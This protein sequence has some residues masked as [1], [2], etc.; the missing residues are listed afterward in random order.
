LIRR[1]QTAGATVVLLAPSAF[2]AATAGS[3]VAGP[4][5]PKFGAATPHRLYDKEV[6]EPN[7]RWLLGLRNKDQM[8]IDIHVRDEEG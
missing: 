5:A 7:G 4:D 1:I 3:K 2:A 8:V 6:L